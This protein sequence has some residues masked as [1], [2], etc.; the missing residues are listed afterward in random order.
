MGV[1]GYL[2]NIVVS[3]MV[4]TT[5]PIQATQ[6]LLYPFESE[7][8][9]V[10]S[11]DGPWN[12]LKSRQDKPMQGVKEK[13]F[14]K[15]LKDVG[16]AIVMPV[17]ASYNDITEDSSLRDHV[18][19]V[20]YD[21]KFFVPKSWRENTLVWLRFGSAHYAAIVWING[22]QVMDHKI[23]HLP[24]EAEISERVKFGQENRITVLVGE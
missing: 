7:S 24:F 23:G 1:I 5:G 22:V 3:V 8:R 4:L 16:N 12:F 15:D 9:E 10:R 20:W 14:L 11:L 17:P 21:R 6:G 2:A 18:G 13:W 19:T